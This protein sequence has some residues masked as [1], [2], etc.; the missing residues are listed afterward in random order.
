MMVYGRA[1]KYK[2]INILVFGG[3][4]GFLGFF[5]GSSCTI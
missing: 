1:A 5:F 4:W 3:V 2:I